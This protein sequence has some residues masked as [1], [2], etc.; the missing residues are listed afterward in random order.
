MERMPFQPEIDTTVHVPALLGAAV[1]AAG[2][3]RGLP[4]LCGSLVVLRELRMS[5]A[6][7]LLAAMSTED[8]A[9]F[10][11]P[12]PTTIEGFE[13]FIAWAHR[14]RA[15]G[16]YLSFAVVARGDDRPIGLFQIRSLEPDFGC[17]EWGF[18]LAV[19]YWGTG[20]FV[21]AARLAIDFA[22]DV[23]GAHRLEARVALTNGRGNAALKK[24]GATREG[25]LRRSLLRNGEFLDQAL[26]TIVADE[27]LRTRAVDAPRIVH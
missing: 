3:R 10:I 24:L 13:K 20:L 18:A 7:A 26:W 11:S 5:D 16:R 1:A 21:D 17:S 2:W 9:R 14:E 27:W 23:V 8:V 4:T 25:V 19:E 15:V 6:E 22:F 12:P